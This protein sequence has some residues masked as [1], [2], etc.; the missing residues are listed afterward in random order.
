MAELYTCTCMTSHFFLQVLDESVLNI[1]SGV[2]LL[3]QSTL[4]VDDPVT[5]TPL[6]DT[7]QLLHGN[8]YVQLYMCNMTS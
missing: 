6:R 8:F 2:V 3:I 1:L 7:L 4:A 5:P